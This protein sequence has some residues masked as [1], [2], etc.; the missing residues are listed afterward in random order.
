[1]PKVVFSRMLYAVAWSNTTLMRGDLEAPIHVQK[2][3]PDPGLVVI[4]SGTIV[5]QLAQAGVIDEYK[6]MVNPVVLSKGE[7]CSTASHIHGTSN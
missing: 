6:I 1:M 2:H 5:S 4:G 3:A 7:P